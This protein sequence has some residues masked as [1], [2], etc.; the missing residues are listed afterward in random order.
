MTTRHQN[1]SLRGLRTFCIVAE[2]E[3]FR[4]AADKLFITAS[5]V[6]HQIRNL[7]DELGQKL[8]E[9]RSRSIHLTE[10]GKSFYE[11]INPL[12]NELDGVTARHRKSQE[13]SALTISV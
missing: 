5:A 7:E 8:F 1:I 6:S 10:A 4:D 3:S 9:R 2:H 12:I 11:D 13:R